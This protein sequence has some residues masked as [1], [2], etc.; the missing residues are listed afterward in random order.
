M[1]QRDIGRVFFRFPLKK[2]A[3]LKQLIHN[4]G[5]AGWKSTRYARLCSAD[6]EESCFEVDIFPSTNGSRSFKTSATENIKA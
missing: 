3:V 4:C 6:F 2:Q 1:I 5:Q